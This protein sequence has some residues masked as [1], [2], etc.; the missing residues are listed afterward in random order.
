MSEFCLLT[1]GLNAFLLLWEHGFYAYRFT[2]D[3]PLYHNFHFHFA[4]GT[5]NVWYSRRLFALHF[6]TFPL[7]TSYNIMA[8]FS[9]KLYK[10]SRVLF[11]AL[12]VAQPILLSKFVA[13]HNSNDDFYALATMFLIP[14]FYW[15]GTLYFE[16]LKYR[17]A[18]VWFSYSIVFVI[19]MGVI[20]GRAVIEDN[21]LREHEIAT[22]LCNVTNITTES[23]SFFDSKF[24]K[25]TLCFTPGILPA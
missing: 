7:S 6:A 10:I 21:K 8:C 2:W 9:V 11:F 13:D 17:L 25:I 24:L 15:A 14:L 3:T 5:I 22:C 23:Q 19:M 1:V 20:F 4:K 12:L 16:G 18:S